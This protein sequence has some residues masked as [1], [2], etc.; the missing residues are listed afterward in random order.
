[1]PTKTAVSS[2]ICMKCG[3]QAKHRHHI[4]YEPE[5]LAP[6]CKKCHTLITFWNRMIGKS[7]RKKLTNR[8]RIKIWDKFLIEELNA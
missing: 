4:I 6:L 3:K 2:T 5:Y 1:M 7:L 8:A